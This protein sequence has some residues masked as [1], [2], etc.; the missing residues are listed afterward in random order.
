MT[1]SNA[2][3]PNGCRVALSA[4]DER[5]VM[6]DPLIENCDHQPEVALNFAVVGLAM[7]SAVLHHAIKANSQPASPR[8]MLEEQVRIETRNI[9]SPRDRHRVPI[10]G[11]TIEQRTDR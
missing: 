7:P 6:L 1:S 5:D 8:F 3:A 11:V 4:A 9:G 2:N 10:A